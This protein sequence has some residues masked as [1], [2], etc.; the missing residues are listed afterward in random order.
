MSVPPVTYDEWLAQQAALMGATPL[1][2]APV[3]DAGGS[4][5]DPSSYVAPPPP[6]PPPPSGPTHLQGYDDGAARQG[7]ASYV[8]APAPAP[9]QDAGGSGYDPSTYVPPA[10]PA[11]APALPPPAPTYDANYET[12]TPTDWQQYQPAPQMGAAGWEPATNQ[13]SPPPDSTAGGTGNMGYAPAPPPLAPASDRYPYETPTAEPGS[14]APYAPATPVPPP[15]QTN[16]FRV[17]ADPATEPLAP[18]GETTTPETWR[19]YSSSDRINPELQPA[20]DRQGSGPDILRG[21]VGAAQA[22]GGGIQTVLNAPTAFKR[23]QYGEIAVKI[24]RGE[25]LNPA[26]QAWAAADRT[27]LADFASKPENKEYILGAAV[28]GWQA[29][30]PGDETVDA[31][32]YNDAASRQSGLASEEIQDEPYY[33]GATRQGGIGT[34]QN[35]T[36]APGG[37]AVWEAYTN[38]QPR[39]QRA[40][41][42]FI[43]DPWNALVGGKAIREGGRAA[44]LA[45]TTKGGRFLG[46]A[47]QGL[48][49][50]VGAPDYATDAL[51]APLGA[52]GSKIG[53][54]PALTATEEAAQTGAPRSGMFQTE[55]LAEMQRQRDQ[56]LTSAQ[57]ADRLGV[58]LPDPPNLG[59]AAPPAGPTLPTPP[60]GSLVSPPPS[61]GPVPAALPTSPPGSIVSLPP[62]LGQTPAAA[63]PTLPAAAAVPTPPTL[64][65]PPATTTAAVPTAPVGQAPSAPPLLTP[66]ATAVSAPPSLSSTPAALPTAPAAAAMPAPPS[67]ATNPNLPTGPIPLDAKGQAPRREAASRASSA[68]PVRAAGAYHEPG[69][70]EIADPATGTTRPLTNDELIAQ[71]EQQAVMDPAA[72]DSADSRAWR[73]AMYDRPWTEGGPILKDTP[74]GTPSRRYKPLP[75]EQLPPLDPAARG[76]W[77]GRLSQGDR[78][79]F[80]V[81]EGAHGRWL[82]LQ[83]N[84]AKRDLPGAEAVW[85]RDKVP[86]TVRQTI[87][88]RAGISPI[89]T[90]KP[91]MAAAEVA[92]IKIGPDGRGIAP[93]PGPAAIPIPTRDMT[94]PADIPITGGLPSVRARVDAAMAMKPPATA[95]ARPVDIPI[96]GALPI[97]AA[98]AMKPDVGNLGTTPISISGALPPDAATAMKPPTQLPTITDLPSKQATGILPN[99]VRRA[100]AAMAKQDQAAF[101]TRLNQTIDTA[102]RDVKTLLSD[103]DQHILLDA[104]LTKRTVTRGQV[105]GERY[106]TAKQLADDLKNGIADLADTAGLKARGL[107]ELQA[108]ELAN[109]RSVGD[110]KQTA[111]KWM[112]DDV[113]ADAGVD[114]AKESA[115]KLGRVWDEVISVQKERTRWSPLNGPKSVLTDFLGNLIPMTMTGNAGAAL[116]GFNP[117]EFLKHFRNV[118]GATDDIAETAAGRLSENLGVGIPEGLIRSGPARDEL[119]ATSQYGQGAV[120]RVLGRGLGGTLKADKWGG[121]LLSS[122]FLRE[123]G[124]GLESVLRSNIWTTRVRRQ[125]PM[126]RELLLRDVEQ[127]FGRFGLG[128][129]QVRGQIAKLGKEFDQ[130]RLGAALTDLERTLP[131][132]TSPGMVVRQHRDFQS[133]VAG[134]QKRWANDIRSMSDNAMKEVEHT[135]FSYRNTNLDKG[136]SRLFSFHYYN[137]RAVPLYAQ[138]GMRHPGLA[139]NYFRATEGLER[140]AEENDWPDYWKNYAKVM[141][142]PLGWTM[143]WAPVA[144]VATTM[145]FRDA[146]QQGG[147]WFDEKIHNSPIGGMVNP[148]M[149]AA[150]DYAGFYGNPN[151]TPDPAVMRRDFNYATDVLN[152]LRAQGVL[153]EKTPVS[154]LYDDWNRWGRERASSVV[155]GVLPFVDEVP[156]I[157]GLTADT[158][159]INQFIWDRARE[160]YGGT[161]TPEQEREA[162]AAMSDPDSEWYQE[163]FEQDAWGE[164]VKGTLGIFVPGGVSGIPTSELERK[165]LMESAQGVAKEDQTSEQQAAFRMSSAANQTPERREMAALDAAYDA[166]GSEEGRY[167]NKAYND[168]V[169]ANADVKPFRVNGTTYTQEYL[170]SLTQEERYAIADATFEAAN[171]GGK[172]IIDEQRAAQTAFLQENP[173][174]AGAREFKELSD[175]YAP[176]VDAWIE[177]TAA[178]NEAYRDYLDNIQAEP[179]SEDYRYF[180]TNESASLAAQGKRGSLYDP[181]N[182]GDTGGPTPFVAGLD[183]NTTL[184]DA[185]L[186]RIAEDAKPSERE[187]NAMASPF[188]AW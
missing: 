86:S 22:V 32:Y 55:P 105:L 78:D 100:T 4:G 107:T 169:F 173:D 45:A 84:L 122:Q 52:V 157:S 129:D 137:T 149:D 25:S 174:Y 132:P 58:L 176:G 124:N 184:P 46:K 11:P 102:P 79:R 112:A 41:Q 128:R 34:N 154:S 42:D 92:G 81:A 108:K 1:A 185:A 40:A 182:V 162:T 91:S 94:R 156:A 147:N 10:A 153:G 140:Q 30:D 180:A 66:A 152:Q 103:A 158:N 168:I 76:S 187:L 127:A 35:P 65:A 68:A 183:P 77:L 29:P 135:L 170:A 33:E 7:G 125:L 83:A 24:A 177:D 145:T 110:L 21:A 13:P 43:G 155:S 186:Q 117:S 48:G 171:I 146:D 144:L 73:G 69:T 67:I 161:L 85:T 178:G 179:G 98:T 150:F 60:A 17:E 119:G 172:Q 3:M 133:L 90:S 138:E 36:Y 121:A 5:Y 114:L 75:G 37:N 71:F 50:L 97:D 23:E 181:T 9:V 106:A 188:P 143:M 18:Q 6:L 59:T 104:P 82:D 101:D 53:K 130:V 49:M 51:L 131:Q 16:Q 28:G 115:T 134:T 151:R 95:A 89:D 139:A 62:N 19:R 123:V 64:G 2:P 113:L 120:R 141:N 72:F 15:P 38:T 166:V 57:T 44:E 54:R 12:T 109:A 111:V 160:T 148:L 99:S 164:F 80:I 14:W 74:P 126:A 56:I 96:T 20:L 70:W 116:R 159:N 93:N 39:Y 142:S 167:A 136:I 175:E 63:T 8:P 26:E 61:L 47:Q 163:A 88:T 27:G 31:N 165:A 118:K 87:K